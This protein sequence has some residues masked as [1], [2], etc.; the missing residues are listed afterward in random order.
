MSDTGAFGQEWLR[1]TIQG[2][3]VTTIQFFGNVHD[4]KRLWSRT[5]VSPPMPVVSSCSLPMIVV[6]SLVTSRSGSGACSGI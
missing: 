1:A 2:C 5:Y 4:G 6:G 3:G